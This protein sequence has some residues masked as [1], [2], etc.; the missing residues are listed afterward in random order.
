MKLDEIRKEIEKEKSLE[1]WAKRCT[2]HFTKKVKRRLFEEID[3]MVW[4]GDEKEIAQWCK[5]NKVLDEITDAE[6]EEILTGEDT[7]G[8]EPIRLNGKCVWE[9]AKRVCDF[10][11]AHEER[12]Q[13]TSLGEYRVVMKIIRDIEEAHIVERKRRHTSRMKRMDESK[14]RTQRAKAPIAEIRR[15]GM[16]KEEI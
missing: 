8:N 6:I 10:I 2:H 11:N 3:N 16:R 12:I 14:T 15:R 1:R 4:S 9:T 5:R 7:D 13:I